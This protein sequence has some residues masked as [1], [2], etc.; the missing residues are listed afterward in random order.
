MQTEE[1]VVDNC[2][3]SN[4][5]RQTVGLIYLEELF[6]G[7]YIHYE[8]YKI[9]HDIALVCMRYVSWIFPGTVRAPT[10]DVFINNI[11]WTAD[12]II[13][14]ACISTNKM[15]CYKIVLMLR[16]MYTVVNI[17]FIYISIYLGVCNDN[18]NN[19]NN[20]NKKIIIM[21]TMITIIVI[22]IYLS[23]YLYMCACVH[24]II[25]CIFILS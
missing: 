5:T 22:S 20:N 25:S 9:I 16:F 23:I 2:P 21:I 15:Y 11:M 19:N 10:I 7:K 13:C 8:F 4:N 17:L 6:N 24:F 3:V 1:H 12:Y 14:V 18:N